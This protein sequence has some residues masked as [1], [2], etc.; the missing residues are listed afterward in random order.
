MHEF[1]G[2]RLGT[3]GHLVCPGSRIGQNLLG[4]PLSFARMSLGVPGYLRGLGMRIGER[5]LG[6]LL[7]NVGTPLGVPN[8]LLRRCAR[9]RTNRVRFTPSIRDMFLS[10][11]L[12]QSEDLESLVLSSGVG[13]SVSLF[14]EL[15]HRKWP[16]E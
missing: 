4:V 2:I 1:V 13:A 14:Q 15:I 6:F 9:I 3:F 11:S 16:S 8:Y 10:S 7:Q 12:S 5:F